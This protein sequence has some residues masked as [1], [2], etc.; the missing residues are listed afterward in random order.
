M[1]GL[2]VSRH[3]AG[4]FTNR[5]RPGAGDGLDD[6]PTHLGERLK[7]QFRRFKRDV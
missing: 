2:Y 6:V 4:N 3:V 7:Q 5:Q 1:H